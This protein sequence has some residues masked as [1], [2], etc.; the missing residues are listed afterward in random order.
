MIGYLEYDMQNMI[1]DNLF[2]DDSFIIFSNHMNI[3]EEEDEMGTLVC[4]ST[5]AFYTY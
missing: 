5:E 1:R 4:P 3:K 2:E